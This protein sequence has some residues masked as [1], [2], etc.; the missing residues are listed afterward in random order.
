MGMRCETVTIETENGPVVINESDFDGSVH[1]LFKADESNQ[2]SNHGTKA[3][4]Q[5]QLKEV[6]IVYNTGDN[7][8][9][10]QSLLDKGTE[11]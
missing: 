1:E 11:D 8:A 4:L 6:G 10:L 3:W 7:K 2:G 9:E 5:E